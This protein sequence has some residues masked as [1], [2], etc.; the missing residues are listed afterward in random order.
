MQ[1]SHKYMYGNHMPTPLATI[2]VS[3]IPPDAEQSPLAVRVFDEQMNHSQAVTPFI[4][5]MLHVHS[6]GTKYPSDC[7]FLPR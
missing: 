7:V 3:V 4:T 6:Y 5:L 2:E 1:K